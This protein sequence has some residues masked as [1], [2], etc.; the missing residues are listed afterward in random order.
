M[1]ARDRRAKRRCHGLDTRIEWWHL[2][3]EK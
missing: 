3:D 1:D 2:K